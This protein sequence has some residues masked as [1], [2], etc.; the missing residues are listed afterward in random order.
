MQKEMQT[1]EELNSQ[2]QKLAQQLKAVLL[3]NE[4]FKAVLAENERLK[5]VLAENE[6]LKTVLAQNEQLKAEIAALKEKVNTNS[7]NSS[8]PP[9]Q[10]PNRE[11]RKKEPTGKKRGGQ[12]GHS[13]NM[14]QL[15][16]PEDVT[17]MFEIKPEACPSCGENAFDDQPVRTEI[18]Q[19]TEL[20]EIKPD[21]Y[22]YNIHTCRCGRCGKH[23]KAN[24]PQEA[25]G[26]FGPRLMGFMAILSAEFH[27]PK[28]KVVNLLGYLN[29]RISLGT[30]CKTQALAGEILEGPYETI[31][32]FTLNQPHVNGD[33]TSWKIQ[34][35]RC[36][37]WIATTPKSVFF[38]IDPSRSTEAFRRIYGNDFDKLL[39]T[40]RYSAYNDHE[41]ER[42]LCLGHIDRDF[43]KI[44]GRGD[45]DQ[46][47]GEHLKKE[48]DGVFK[49]W[50]SYKDGTISHAEMRDLI[51]SQHL[52]AFKVI[53][54]IGSI[55]ANVTSKTQNTCDNLLKDFSKMWTFLKH[56][57][58]EPTNNL[59][60]RDI[61]HG[62]LWRKISFG[63]QSESGK[64]FVQRMLTIVMTLKKQAQNSLN[65]LV[66]FFQAHK[67][68]QEIPHPQLL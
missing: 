15:T 47:V 2:I 14:R 63:N 38:S 53:F 7:S 45:F 6:Q 48:I 57:G 43:E 22:Q 5:A 20:P 23:V 51:E 3:E 55:A 58:V 44:E 17:E 9:S 31:R 13:R 35:K 67:T 65:Y 62:V 36:W 46:T 42:Q 16:P 21:V 1:Y 24:V 34:G 50:H 49:C 18:R 11:P 30:V 37:L 29:I 64:I 4:Q 10:D 33:E 40:D 66:K 12:P 41:G 8:K 61:R 54:E 28:R 39:T 68:G 52:A 26:A 56:E 25:I 60:E 19:V 32:Q 27:V 59:A